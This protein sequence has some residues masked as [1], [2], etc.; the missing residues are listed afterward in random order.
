M[1]TTI[2]TNTTNKLRYNHQS[3]Y[4]AQIAQMD[5]EPEPVPDGMLQYTIFE[6]I[7]HILGARLYRFDR[8][9][10]ILASG[11]TFICYD[12]EDLNVRVSPDFYLAIGVDAE[13]IRQRRVYL[14]WEVGKA[15]DLVLEV[16]SESTAK[17]DVIDKRVIYQRIGAFEYWRVD[18]TGGEFYG[19]ALAGDRLV[20]GTYRAVELTQQADGELRGYSEVLGLYL[21]YYD[22]MLRF[23]DPE[24][25]EYLRNLVES[26]ERLK[27]S[28]YQ[29]QAAEDER[30]VAEDERRVAEVTQRMLE[31]RNAELEAEIRHLRN[32][33]SNGT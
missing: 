13:T 17:N 8:D 3:R 27:T 33:R 31:Q 7:Y 32:Q 22:G 28:E 18:P 26:E 10:N 25:G 19:Y 5:W 1:T 23:Y 15:P 29:R 30:R 16:A 24:T 11:D 14:P 21:C 2:A 6:Q 12:P 4:D 9:S 20:D